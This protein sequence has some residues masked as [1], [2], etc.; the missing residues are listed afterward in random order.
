MMSLNK[1]ELEQQQQFIGN[2]LLEKHHETRHSLLLPDWSSALHFA[3][4]SK[5]PRY[6]MANVPI[7]MSRTVH[8]C[9]CARTHARR[10][11]LLQKEENLR[12]QMIR[13]YIINTRLRLTKK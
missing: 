5:P 11:E 3:M 9:T 12:L 4:L 1:V 6:F 13:S 7:I 8:V 2:S 10:S